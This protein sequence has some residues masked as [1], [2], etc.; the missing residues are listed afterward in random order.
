[1]DEVPKQ[2]V[3]N[4]GTTLGSKATSS[5]EMTGMISGRSGKKDRN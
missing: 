5:T 3:R 2:T 1:M 4:E